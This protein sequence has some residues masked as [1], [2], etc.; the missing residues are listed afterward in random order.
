MDEDMQNNKS[1]VTARLLDQT[2]ELTLDPRLTGTLRDDTARESQFDENAFCG[3]ERRDIH[4]SR[5]GSRG[6]ADAGSAGSLHP[7]SYDS[8]WCDHGARGFGRRRRDR[9]Q[10]A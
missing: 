3:V 5:E 10:F 7:R 6:G 8:R 4:R 1:L 9:Y 2:I